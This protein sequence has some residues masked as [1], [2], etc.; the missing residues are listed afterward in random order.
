MSNSYYTGDEHYNHKNIIKYCNRSFKNIEEMNET[1]IEN[2]NK[3]V[4]YGDKVY[5]VGDFCFGLGKDIVDRLNGQHYLIIGSHDRNNQKIYGTMV[6]IGEVYEVK[7]NNTFIFLNHYAQ[8][9]WP[10]SHYGSWHLFGHSHGNL[11]SYGKSF[12]VGVDSH[13]F[14]PWSYSEIKERMDSIE[15][16]EYKIFE[17]RWDRPIKSKE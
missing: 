3:V 17:S 6:I 16:T 9:V 14:T 5:H 12:D 10:K 11:P 4:K 8:R 1:M 13:N 2:N 7:I 15:V